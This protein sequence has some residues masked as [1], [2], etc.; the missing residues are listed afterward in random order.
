MAMLRGKM[1]PFPICE[2][3]MPR[4]L[5]IQTDAAHSDIQK[6]YDSFEKELGFVPNYIKTLAHSPHYLG[7]IA[8]VYLQLH[9][10]SSLSEKLRQLLILKTCKLDR[11]KS[12]LDW[13]QEQALKAGWTE[14]QLGATEAFQDS[15]HFNQ[16]ERDALVLV[17]YL[18]TA[19]DEIPQN[20]FWTTLDNHFTSD[21]VVEMISLVG[22]VNMVN[23]FVLAVEVESDPIPVEAG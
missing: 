19:P 3:T 8:K 5:P 22:V 9:G 1:L 21:Q 16:Y 15:D 14:E 4:Y 11:C 6:V 13:H 7:P 23:R 10:E 17:E 2:E 20:A 12:T 18:L